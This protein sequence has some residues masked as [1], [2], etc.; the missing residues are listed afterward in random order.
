MST[1][2]ARLEV[3]CRPAR[4]S[5]TADMLELTSGIWDGNDYV[6]NI[7]AEWLADPDGTLA[8]A[9]HQGRVL[10]LGKLTRL[11]KRDWWLEGLR[12]HPEYQGRGV[13]SQLNDYL[14]ARWLGIGEG[15]IR[16][17]TNSTRLQVHH[18]C[19]RN[20][21]VKIAEFA[22][23]AAPA[24]A[25]WEQAVGGGHDTTIF[26]PL[27]ASQLSEAVAFALE[28]AS[29]A[30]SSGL[31]DLSWQWAPPAKSY[32]A[33][34]VERQRAWWWR[35]QRGLLVVGEDREGEPLTIIKL[36]ACSLEDIPA[37]LEDY[38]RLAAAMGFAKAGWMAP[39]RPEL[40]SLLEAA[41]FQRE[42][43]SS[44]YV[45]EKTSPRS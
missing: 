20:S 7:W 10:G 6:P 38:R 17:G 34:E 25:D 13:A 43:E 23:Y 37:C 18:M 31:M 3:L 9:E 1:D 12:V 29:L 44:L 30:L 33:R 15:T 27:T 35:E 4:P 28:S 26:E 42:T 2:E 14:V 24:L 21:F 22:W 8:V 11:S 32:L 5:D 36:L 45:Y 41:G 16:L 39:L 40:F 19:Q